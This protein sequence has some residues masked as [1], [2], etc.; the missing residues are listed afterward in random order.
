MVIRD[1]DNEFMESLNFERNEEMSVCVWRSILSQDPLRG[2]FDPARDFKGEIFVDHQWK[3]GKVVKE[4]RIT[5]CPYK[6]TDECPWR[7][8]PTI[9]GDI[10]CQAVRQTAFIRDREID[11]SREPRCKA[12]V[13]TW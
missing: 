11:N 2:G 4:I 9:T 10:W 8:G 6:N 5:V 3:D 12:H 7:W 1:E 13:A